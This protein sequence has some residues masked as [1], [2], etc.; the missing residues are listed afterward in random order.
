MSEWNK[1]NSAHRITW[2]TLYILR[3]HRSLFPGAGSLL[4]PDLVF[5][6]KTS[7]ADLRRSLAEMIALQVHSVFISQFGVGLEDGKTEDQAVS[8]MVTILV[9]ELKSIHDLSE[10]ND[11]SYKFFNEEDEPI[12]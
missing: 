5:F 7:D 1:N 4:M 3:Q 8:E 12:L 10:V 9:D 11:V 2:I 6:N